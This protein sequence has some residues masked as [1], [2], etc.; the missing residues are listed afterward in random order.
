MSSTTRTNLHNLI[1]AAQSAVRAAESHGSPDTL[2]GIDAAL[3]ALPVNDMDGR[4]DCA[5]YAA[6]RAVSVAE[7]AEEW[8]LLADVEHQVSRL[9]IEPDGA[10]DEHPAVLAVVRL[11]ERCGFRQEKAGAAVARAWDRG[12]MSGLQAMRKVMG[13]IGGGTDGRALDGA[14]TE[15]LAAVRRAIAYSALYEARGALA[16]AARSYGLFVVGM[17]QTLPPEGRWEYAR[18]IGSAYYLFEVVP[19]FVEGH[20]YGSVAVRRDAADG[21]AGPVRY[22]PF[23]SI[24]A[25]DA[26][27][28]ALYLI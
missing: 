9:M 25:L 13:A 8:E 6:I 18:R 19:P 26:A 14:V 10:T 11:V 27:N 16:E 23:S 17:R 21:A 20:P 12:F 3:C 15:F 24:K 2:R 4:A 5:L 7:D 1:T 22:F 28:E